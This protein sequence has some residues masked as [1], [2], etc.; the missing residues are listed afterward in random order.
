M[1]C[2][3]GENVHRKNDSLISLGRTCRREVSCFP[4]EVMIQFRKSQKIFSSDISGKDKSLKTL[5]SI[6]S[7]W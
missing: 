5:K 6:E 1:R 2:V 4:A 3:Y 7:S